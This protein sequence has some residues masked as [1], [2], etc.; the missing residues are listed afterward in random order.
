MNPS[1]HYDVQVFDFCQL[2]QVYGKRDKS[3]RAVFLF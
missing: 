1:Q 3:Y 2:M